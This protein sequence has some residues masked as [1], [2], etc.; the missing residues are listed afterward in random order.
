[1]TQS[2]VT[3]VD[4]AAEV[5]WGPRSEYSHLPEPIEN[6]WVVNRDN[7]AAR[8][9]NPNSSHKPSSAL[10]ARRGRAFFSP[11]GAPSTAPR[12]PR[13]A[14]PTDPKRPQ[15]AP[16]GPSANA[17]TSRGRAQATSR[18]RGRGSDPFTSGLPAPTWRGSR[19]GPQPL[20][21]GRAV[22]IN[23][24]ARKRGDGPSHNEHPIREAYRGRG[25]GYHPRGDSG[26][27]RG[28]YLDQMPESRSRGHAPSDLESVRSQSRARQKFP[29][30][31]PMNKSFAVAEDEYQRNNERITTDIPV[32]RNKP[33]ASSIKSSVSP[34]LRYPA[35]S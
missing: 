23:G 14:P 30:V 5:S 31:I 9:N 20:G 19:N 6:A 18:G 11:R 10:R 7:A 15:G 27:Q 34:I 3:S 29:K 17:N 4:I 26:E 28:R 25:K 35:L 32:L 22:T 24:E 2:K 8:L 12:G 13:G 33:E 16:K 1:M 21:H